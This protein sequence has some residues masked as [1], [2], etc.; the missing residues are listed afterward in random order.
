M[1]ITVLLMTK[2]IIKFNFKLMS[3]SAN[4]SKQALETLQALAK[5]KKSM[6]LKEKEWKPPAN[7]MA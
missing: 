4:L 6:E 5:V 2:F 1:S 3:H 7:E